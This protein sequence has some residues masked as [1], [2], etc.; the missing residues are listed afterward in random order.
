MRKRRLGRTN[1]EVSELSLGTWG[2]SGEGYGPTA[3]GEAERVIQRALAMGVTL[4]ETAAH[5]RGGAIEAM[6][7]TAL[8]GRADVTAVVRIG[9]DVV[10]EPPRKRFDRPFLDEAVARSKERLGDTRAV[11]LLHNPSLRALEAG[12]AQALVD[13]RGSKAIA[14]WGVSVGSLEVARAALA[15][16]AEVLS[17]PFNVLQVQPLRE[18]R[19][20]LV[21]K[22]VGVLA[23]SVL[24]YGV[25]AGRWPP[26]KEFPPRDHRSERW[27]P[28]ALRQRVRQLDAL[29]PLVSGDVTSLR[30][31]ALRFVL[32]ESAISSAIVG[33]RTGAQLDQLVRDVQSE[34]PY[35][36]AAKLDALEKRLEHLEVPR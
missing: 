9:T 13:L 32:C 5:Y 6:L 31:A 12:A 25:L 7:G 20:E 24:A 21:E 1:I 28:G 15:A 11:V 33:P 8:E 23:H 29:R 35:L 3:E 30:S 26:S 18:L 16:E 27:P 17:F 22:D 36:S 2:L 4:F 14:A 34:P 10:T 19:D